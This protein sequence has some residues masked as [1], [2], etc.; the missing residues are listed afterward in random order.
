MRKLFLQPSPNFRKGSADT[1]PV[2]QGK[3][4]ANAGLR[5]CLAMLATDH[6]RDAK[7]V[8]KHLLSNGNYGF[9]PRPHSQKWERQHGHHRAVLLWLRLGNQPIAVEPRRPEG[10]LLDPRDHRVLRRVPRG[11]ERYLLGGH[12]ARSNALAAMSR[13]RSDLYSSARQPHPKMG[14][15]SARSKPGTRSQSRIRYC[16][17][18]KPGVRLH[19]AARRGHRARFRPMRY[20]RT[21]SAISNLRAI[22]QTLSVSSS[23]PIQRAAR[24]CKEVTSAPKPDF[25]D[26]FRQDCKGT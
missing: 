17:T 12:R 13:H 11:Q 3:G 7:T 26:L 5:R 2:R 1:L 9:L 24:L 4:P 19:P 16:G 25:P 8:L 23:M 6:G 10:H 18:R 22:S 14:A 15:R 21:S 20:P